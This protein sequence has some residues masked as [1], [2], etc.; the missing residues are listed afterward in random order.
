MHIRILMALAFLPVPEVLES[1]NLL[2]ILYTEK[3]C[4]LLPLLKYFRSQWIPLIPVWNVHAHH[5]RTNND[6]EAWHFA[7]K[8]ILKRP[9]PDIFTFIG[10]F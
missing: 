4:C 9:H 3:L 7:M 2:S 1:F 10:T 8:R 5:I 6:L